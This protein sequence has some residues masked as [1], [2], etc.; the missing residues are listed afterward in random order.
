[1]NIKKEMKKDEK[2]RKR[3]EERLNEK[4]KGNKSGSLKSLDNITFKEYGEYF[5]N[6]KN[7][8]EIYYVSHKLAIMQSLK[9][10]IY[11]IDKLNLFKTKKERKQILDILWDIFNNGSPINNLLNGFKESNQKTKYCTYNEY[12]LLKKYL[13]TCNEAIKLYNEKS[14][15]FLFYE[16]LNIDNEK[17]Y[18]N[19]FSLFNRIKNRIITIFKK[20]NR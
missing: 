1:M 19:Q 16:I 6:L 14:L 15:N 7:E 5:N 8:D 9:E 18:L 17:E 11:R 12:K 13:K 20:E 10:F 2:I 4:E 3:I